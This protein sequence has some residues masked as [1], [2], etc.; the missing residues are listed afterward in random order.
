MKTVSP[1][2]AQ[3]LAQGA[4]TLT[5]CWKIERTDGAKFFYTELDEDLTYQGDVYKSAAGFNKSAITSSATF[6][7]DKLEVTGFLRDDGISD[8][9]IRNGA[10]DHAKV[11]VFM[12]NY[13]D[14]SMGD[15]KLRSGWFGEVRTT[16]S[17]AFL[18]ELR[19]LVDQLQVKVGRTYLPE[20]GVDLGSP[21]CGIKLIPELRSAGGY[22]SQGDRI[23]WPVGVP[24]YV[25]SKHYPQLVDPNIDGVW[26]TNNLRKQTIN[27]TPY[28]GPTMVRCGTSISSPSTLSKAFP[29]ASVEFSEAKAASGLYEVE[30]R[31]RAYRMS[32]STKGRIAVVCQRESVSP[33]FF[34]DI[35]TQE[36]VIPDKP[37]HRKWVEYV[38]TLDVHP[39]TDRFLVRLIA[40]PDPTGK[41]TSDV[42]FDDLDFAIKLKSEQISAFASYGGIEFEA[43]TSGKTTTSDV[44]FDPILD[45]ETIDGT[46]TWKA[47]LPKYT[48][49]RTLTADM[50]ATNRLKIDPIAM[51]WTNF[52][53]W[54]VVKF[55]SGENAGRAMEIQ[56]YNEST[57][58]VRLALPIPYQGKA[59]DIIS[60]Q[61]GCNKT[62]K[63]CI[64]FDN[65]LN[66]RGFDRIPGQGQYFKIAGM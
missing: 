42:Y 47:V 46:V 7:V 26:P 1:A 40:D 59:G 58:D 12:V 16:G 6:A 5:T 60:V 62:K 21:K 38:A 30:F 28:K 11:Q 41:T 9:E 48:F 61:A 49:L 4:T 17:G 13:M 43:Q 29:F 2:M 18:V 55:L 32:S 34:L 27:V 57:G 8:E 39:D 10:F 35:T 19:G 24:D 20:C 66:F 15:I 65:V 3:H 36:V 53:D 52:F 22:Y 44:T 45:A 64:L 54:G 51:A 50:T 33:G 37:P 23:V 14:L 25:G 63:N 31:A 56:N